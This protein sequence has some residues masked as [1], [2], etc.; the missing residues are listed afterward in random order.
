MKYITQSYIPFNEA[1][2]MTDRFVILNMW[3]EG[4]WY[5]DRQHPEWE[6]IKET[7]LTIAK[8]FGDQEQIKKLTES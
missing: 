5:V 2:Y 3:S 1:F 7:A 6:K 8:T 4:V